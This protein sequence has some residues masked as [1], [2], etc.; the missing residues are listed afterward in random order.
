MFLFYPSK[1]TSPALL[2]DLFYLQKKYSDE[3]TKMI[4]GSTKNSI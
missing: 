3:I 2:S 1:T 4:F